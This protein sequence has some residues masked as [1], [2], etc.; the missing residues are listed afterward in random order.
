V[1]ACLRGV[2]A[3]AQAAA[4]ARRRRSVAQHARAEAA[5]S[6]ALPRQL[7]LCPGGAGEA[8]RG[9]VLG[10]EG[11][12]A[13]GPE[14]DGVGTRGRGPRRAPASARAHHLAG[15][16]VK[17]IERAAA[18]PAPRPAGPLR[19]RRRGGPVVPAVAAVAAAAAPG[20]RAGRRLQQVADARGRRGGAARAAPLPVG[21]RGRGRVPR[22][23]PR[24]LERR[25][26]RAVRLGAV[27]RRR[28][29]PALAL[30]PGPGPGLHL[31]RPM[32][33][34]L[35]LLRL[36]L[37][38]LPLLMLYLHMLLLPRLR[39]RGLLLLRRERLRRQRP[40]PQ[41]RRRRARPA[42]AAAARVGAGRLGALAASRDA[43][44]QQREQGQPLVGRLSR[45]R[46]RHGRRRLSCRGGGGSP[47]GARGVGGA[48]PARQVAADA[49]LH[50][51]VHATVGVR[52]AVA[53]GGRFGSSARALRCASLDTLIPNV[54]SRPCK[55]RLNIHARRYY[56]TARTP[57]DL[58][59]TPTST[60][61]AFEK[62]SSM[63][64][65]ADMAPAAAALCL[66]AGVAYLAYRHSQA[67][68]RVGAWIP[69]AERA[70]AG[71]EGGADGPSACSK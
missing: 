31:P 44:G 36:S 70:H 37:Q 18:T 32:L 69:R 4:D 35:L 10:G 60:A 58:I 50:P 53:A 40:P 29:A 12:Q 30:L 11:G 9:G 45:R 23:V 68:A 13:A 39:R 3:R 17:I 56:K 52:H 41:A 46:R 28:R 5:A 19:R 67:V 8:Y 34:L 65:A 64:S 33:L 43:A 48:P 25:G 47:G 22:V 21:S 42:A 24:V 7:R 63:P 14:R 2:L 27:C 61:K 15:S 54:Q 26:P 16:I 20:A 55:H 57:N 51:G 62:S 71:A 38:R 49:R 1:R 59:S 6:D 66:A